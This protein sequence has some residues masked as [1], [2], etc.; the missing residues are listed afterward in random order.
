MFETQ[1]NPEK[2]GG[3]TQITITEE[4]Q[5]NTAQKTTTNLMIVFGGI[6]I[7]G[8]LIFCIILAAIIWFVVTRKT[9]KK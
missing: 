3:N 1:Y 6:I 8:I 2:I 9:E 7:L 4:T 5:G